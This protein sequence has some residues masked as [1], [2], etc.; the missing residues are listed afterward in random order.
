MSGPKNPA[1]NRPLPDPS[2]ECASCGGRLDQHG[3]NQPCPRFVNRVIA[4]SPPPPSGG[5]IWWNGLA[6]RKSGKTAMQQSF[7]DEW[8]VAAIDWSRDAKLDSIISSPKEA[9]LTPERVLAAAR[10]D[11]RQLKFATD[12]RLRELTDVAGERMN[13]MADEIDRLK[14]Q[15]AS[16]NWNPRMEKALHEKID[17]TKMHSE[18]ED[19]LEEDYRGWPTPKDKIIF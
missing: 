14:K 11:M 5:Q 6:P 12:Q 10:E 9:A 18:D 19:G 17:Y 2:A 4:A 7:I 16:F 1:V 8:Q 13:A 15:L 3:P